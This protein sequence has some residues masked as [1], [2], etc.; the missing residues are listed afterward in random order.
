MKLK[1]LIIL[2]AT[3]SFISGCAN[4]PAR[5]TEIVNKAAAQVPPTEEKLSTFSKYE[6]LPMTFI[7]EIK[8]DEKKLAYGKQLE[9]K[10]NNTVNALFFEW[11][12][13]AGASGKK[14]LIEPQ[15]TSLRIVSGGARFWAG[16]LAGQSSI[17]LKLTIKDA[18]TGQII[19]SPIIEKAAGSF[20]GAYTI[21]SSDTNLINY[22]ADITAQYLKNNY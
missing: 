14:L 21:G 4:N 12:K 5:Q 17:A 18:T 2:L 8:N 10:I 15:L 6:L 9:E 3:L 7:D 11:E 16:A 22:V 19:G 20:A 1:Y 13:G